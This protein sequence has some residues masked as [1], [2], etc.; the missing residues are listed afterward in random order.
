MF[1]SSR[2]ASNAWLTNSLS[3][4]S[5]HWSSL[6]LRASVVIPHADAVVS[7]LLLHQGL[8]ERGG[9][10]DRRHLERRRAARAEDVWAGLRRLSAGVVPQEPG[11]T[12]SLPPYRRRIARTAGHLSPRTRTPRSAVAPAG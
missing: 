12:E 1:P 10:Q 7:N 3:P 6:C 11:Q 4:S 2:M 9:L 5:L 8:Q